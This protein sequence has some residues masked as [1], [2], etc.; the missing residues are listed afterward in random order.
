VTVERGISPVLEFTNLSKTFGPTKALSGVDFDVRPGEI[1]GLVGRNGSGKSTLI[2]VLSGFHDPDRGTKLKL[3][4]EDI[5]LPLR[6]NDAAQLGM[7]FVH[8]DLGLVP[9]FSI[10]ENLRLGTWRRRGLSKIPWADEKSA[11]AYQLSQFGLKW[12]PLTPVGALPPVDRAIVAIARA[13]REIATNPEGHVL[14]LD[15]PTAYLPSESVD[16]LFDAVKKVTRQGTGVV[17]ISHRTDEILNLTDRIS[18]LRDGRKVATVNTRETKEADLVSLILGQSLNAFYPDHVPTPSKEIVLSTKNVAAGAL[19]KLN[20]T[21]RRGEVLGMTGLMGA[22]HDQVPYA[23]FGALEHTAGTITIKNKKYEKEDLT[24]RK[25]VNQGVALLPGDRTGASGVLLATLT[26]NVGMPVLS[27]YFSGGLLRRNKLKK[28]VGELLRRFDVNP[29]VAGIELRKLSGGNQQK[30]LLAKWIQIKPD[31]L[32]LHEPTQGVDVG[33][34]AAIFGK[35]ADAARAGAGVIVASAEHEDLANICNRVL[36]FADGKVV[37][38]LTGRELTPEKI[39]ELSYLGTRKGGGIKRGFVW[40]P[41]MNG[42]KGPYLHVTRNYTWSPHKVG[43]K[44]NIEWPAP[45][46]PPVQYE[47]QEATFVW[48][49][50]TVGFVKREYRWFPHTVGMQNTAMPYPGP[51]VVKVAREFNL[52]PTGELSSFF[53]WRPHYVGNNEPVYLG[54]KEPDKWKTELSASLAAMVARGEITAIVAEKMA[55]AAGVTL[56]Q[57]QD[58]RVTIELDVRT[59]NKGNVADVDRF[60]HALLNMDQS[61]L[62]V[63]GVRILGIE[64][65]AD[66]TR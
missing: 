14:V 41:H 22:G 52:I 50:H 33:S 63:N 16:K 24:P 4:G 3:R 26:D 7:V 59:R 9:A 15:E 19:P 66:K 12:D 58:L 55:K 5:E 35:I 39:V 28:D 40:R 54:P 1:H 49:P 31:V 45:P 30:A 56:G 42:L 65:Q 32:L 20:I 62:D 18:V 29:P 57:A 38:E 23:L 48:S 43:F 37:A 6:G 46:K 60:K 51:R 2:K 53:V 36:I 11:V 61:L 64:L 25:A 8:Q 13:I 21:L 17:F 10:L 47:K 27:K 34:K 44:T